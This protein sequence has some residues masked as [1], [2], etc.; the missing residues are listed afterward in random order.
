MSRVFRVFDDSPRLLRRAKRSLTAASQPPVER[1]L[2][3]ISAFDEAARRNLYSDDFGHETS[4]YRTA[5]IIEPWF[6]KANGTGIVDAA[7]LADT[8]TYLPNDLLVKMD[9]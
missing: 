8:M 5:S 4:Q 6:A 9:I 2:R 7:L 1:Y 3:W